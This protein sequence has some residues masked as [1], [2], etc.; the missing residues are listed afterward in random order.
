MITKIRTTVN[1]FFTVNLLNSKI[2][3][4]RDK[5]DKFFQKQGKM[6]VIKYTK[7]LREKENMQTLII[8]SK[9]LRDNGSNNVIKILS[10]LLLYGFLIFYIWLI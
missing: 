1:S 2:A 8:I 4:G 9:K 3:I 7:K 6:S 5:S 10:W